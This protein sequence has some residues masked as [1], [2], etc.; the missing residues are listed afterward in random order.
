MHN[1]VWFTTLPYMHTNYVTGVIIT[2]IEC[3]YVHI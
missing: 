1:E 2:E 3:C